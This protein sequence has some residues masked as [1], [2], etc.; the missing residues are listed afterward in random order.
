VLD[1]IEAVQDKKWKNHQKSNPDNPDNPDKLF[2][3]V[4]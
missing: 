3:N 1:F 4:K 2:H